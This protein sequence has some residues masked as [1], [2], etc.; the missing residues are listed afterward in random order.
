MNFDPLNLECFLAVVETGS[1]TKAAQRVFRTQSAV[2]QQ[3]GKLEKAL[4]K[5]L[6]HRGKKFSLT[7]EGE[8]F[9]SY[10]Q[11]ILNLHQECVS[12]FKEPELKG[13]IRFGIPEDF[14]T[15][16]LAEVLAEFAH[17][18][19]HVL[20]NVECDLTLHLLDRFKKNEFDMVLLKMSR[21]EDFPNSV[22]IWSEKLEWV[23]NPHI[24]VMLEEKKILPLVLSPQPCVYYS[25]AITTLEAAQIKWQ[26]VFSSSSYASKLAAVKAGLGITVLPKRMI[27]NYL[28]VLNLSSLPSLDDTHISLLKRE[29]DNPLLSCLES[30][31]LKKL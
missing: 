30:F 9:Y 17:S 29:K 25:R 28:T 4:G 11:K 26:I 14:A 15:I 18:H 10:A 2:S 31:I 20:L 19:P 12:R 5:P 21:P 24:Q 22:D 1:V 3:I 6:F 13:K 8:I 27:P 7:T 23:G 16:L